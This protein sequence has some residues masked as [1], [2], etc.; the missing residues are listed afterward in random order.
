L[1]GFLASNRT[2]RRRRGHAVL[3]ALVLT[4]GVIALGVG[5]LTWADTT[6][7]DACRIPACQ[8]ANN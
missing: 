4:F 8:C 1:I 6:R 5:T 3:H 2:D 7:S